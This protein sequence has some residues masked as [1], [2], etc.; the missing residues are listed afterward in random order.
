M[1]ELEQTNQTKPMMKGTY[2]D[3]KLDKSVELNE[4]MTI[5]QSSK[6]EY[7]STLHNLGG[8]Q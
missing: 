4:T 6:D 8:R 3:D 5:N 1:N 7:E 2:K